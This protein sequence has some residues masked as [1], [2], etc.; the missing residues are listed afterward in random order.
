M[1]SANT[2]EKKR[3]I[4]NNKADGKLHTRTHTHKEKM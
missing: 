2:C 1:E 4:F 3:I